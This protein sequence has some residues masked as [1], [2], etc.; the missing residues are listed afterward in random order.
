MQQDGDLVVE[1][2]A[3]SSSSQLT[4][5]VLY[6]TI[7][8]SEG[9][10]FTVDEINMLSFRIPRE[11]LVFD[12]NCSVGVRARD[13]RTTFFGAWSYAESCTVRSTVQPGT[14]T[15]DDNSLTY[16][17]PL[18]E[19]KWGPPAE[20]NGFIL[21]Y[22][23]RLRNGTAEKDD[24]CNSVCDTGTPYEYSVPIKPDSTTYRAVI[25]VTSSTCF[26]AS[27]EARNGA[28]TSSRSYTS[29]FYKYEP[30][31]LSTPGTVA[32]P[33]TGANRINDD[34]GDDS[35]PIVAISLGVVLI[36]VA[37]VTLV[38]AVVFFK[39]YHARIK[40][41]QASGS[42]KNLNSNSYS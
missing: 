16:T 11:N 38:L 20:T 21:E 23:V 41:A 27:V 34:S 10:V 2:M 24:D 5:T 37:V 39:L 15:V 14:P 25:N 12:Q 18:F 22:I 35:A 19:L 1:W 36:I 3:P 33:G 29:K 40:Q 13:V 17:H 6:D 28:G 30:P 31:I 42:S 32:T 7:P 4:Y 8:S 26:C 9:S